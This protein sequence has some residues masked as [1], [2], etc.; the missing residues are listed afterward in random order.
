MASHRFFI[1]T[2]LIIHFL[3]TP[4]FANDK[5]L[6]KKE[7]ILLSNEAIRDMNASNYEKSLIK[8]RRALRYAIAANDKNL[9]AGLYNTIGANFDGLA[10]S[11][12]AFFIMRKHY[13]MRIKPTM[14]N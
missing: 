11:E 7:I 8:A 3:Y 4:T 5:K 1:V 9:I 6:S 13:N 2:L 14:T 10:E 12:K